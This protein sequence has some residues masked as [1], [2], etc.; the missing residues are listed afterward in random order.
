MAALAWMRSPKCTRR[1]PS[2][3]AAS[4]RASLCPSP[5]LALRWASQ[6]TQVKRGG[7][8]DFSFAE[9]FPM[10]Y[11]Y[12][13]ELLPGLPDEFDWRPHSFRW[14]AHHGDRFD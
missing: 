1:A 12:K 2:S 7:L 8:V 4:K 10:W 3:V 9:F 11:R 5:G 14:G 13:P 6:R